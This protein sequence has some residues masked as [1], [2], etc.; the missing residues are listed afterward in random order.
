MRR[1]ELVVIARALSLSLIINDSALVWSKQTMEDIGESL[2]NVIV[3]ASSSRFIPMLNDIGIRV[4]KNP[5][6]KKRRL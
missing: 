1:C 5:N 2:S 4:N 3:G 6:K